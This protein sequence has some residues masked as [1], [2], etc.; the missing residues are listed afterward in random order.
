MRR[1]LTI[2]NYFLIFLT[3]GFMFLTSCQNDC[4]EIYNP[5]V[6][7]SVYKIN[8]IDKTEKIR[9]YAPFDRVYGLDHNQNVSF[10]K[11]KEAYILPLSPSKDTVC[12]IFEREDDI[13]TLI[14]S[15]KKTSSVDK[16][17]C[18]FYLQFMDLNIV[19]STFPKTYKPQNFIE[20]PE[21]NHFKLNIRI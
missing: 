8:Q 18:G 11:N 5:A 2:I 20:V 19:R 7:L 9:D 21:D 10:D 16:D 13:D 17:N 1:K 15:C 6:E 12:F 14:V 4:R 3:V